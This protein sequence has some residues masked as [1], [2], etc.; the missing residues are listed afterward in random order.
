[1][2]NASTEVC[3]AENSEMVKEG[4]DHQPVVI[5]TKDNMDADKPVQVVNIPPVRFIGGPSKHGKNG[6]HS[7]SVVPRYI[8]SSGNSRGCTVV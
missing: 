8:S 6:Q 5:F 2:E 3:V 7:G 1:M 4:A